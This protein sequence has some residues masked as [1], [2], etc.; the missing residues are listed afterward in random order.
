MIFDIV[1]KHSQPSCIDNSK[2]LVN[3][4]VQTTIANCVVISICNIVEAKYWQYSGIKIK[5]NYDDIYNK[6]VNKNTGLSFDN[7]PKLIHMLNDNPCK[8]KSIF[9][10]SKQD[11]TGFAN[12]KQIL[13]GTVH[14]Y[15]FATI[16]VAPI[17]TV[18]TEPHA[19][20][21]CGYNDAAF[22]IQ[23]TYENQKRFIYVSNKELFNNFIKLQCTDIY[24]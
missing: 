18:C 10:L 17:K 1:D 12:F 23:N 3:R 21:I 16:G 2:L 4:P 13:K 9:N 6:L 20:T 8:V 7:V 14:K 24:W 11:I 5:F 19:L 15:Q 22:K